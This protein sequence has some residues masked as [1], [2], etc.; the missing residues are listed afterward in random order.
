MLMGDFLTLVQYDLPVKVVAV[1]QLLAG[2]GGA[3]DDGRRACPTYG[4][5]HE[6]ATSPPSPAR[7]GIHG[8]RVEDPADVPGAL[9]DALAHKGPALVD[10][11]TDPNA[12]SIPPKITG[13]QVRG[14][15]LSASKMVL[16]GGV[17]KMVQLA[18]S[19][20]RNMPRP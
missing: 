3:G 7:A 5:D 2:H 1:Q 20:L 4:T 9:A 11:V 16:D 6:A 13:E 12:L 8:V 15:A 14:F 19:N 10:V 18:R 17:G